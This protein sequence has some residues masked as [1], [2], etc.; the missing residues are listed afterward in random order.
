MNYC[1]LTNSKLYNLT[2]WGITIAFVIGIFFSQHQL[3]SISVLFTSV[4]LL[5]GLLIG[6]VYG[7]KHRLREVIFIITA[8][9]LFATIGTLRQ[10][11]TQPKHIA[12]HIVN[13]LQNNDPKH[14]AFTI[15]RQIKSNE[16]WSNYEAS[17]F[18][19]G[20]KKATGNILLHIT[21][22][23]ASAVELGKNYIAYCALNPIT[24][25]HFP[26]GFH[27]SNYLLSKGITHQVWLKKEVI[28]LSNSKSFFGER[29]IQT[30]HFL[31]RKLE[32]QGLS[33]NVVQFTKALVLGAKAALS[34]EMKSRFQDA[35]VIH[36]LAISGLHIGVIYFVIQWL[37]KWFLFRY[38]YRIL[39][40][41]LVIAII[42][43]FTYFTGGS[44]SAVRASMMFTCFEIS[45]W[46]LR[47]QHPLNALIAAVFILLS[48]QPNY[49]FSV[50]FQLSVTAVAAIMIGVPKMTP[51]LNVKNKILFKIWQIACVT[52]CAQIGILP[53]SIYYFHQIPMLFL[54]ANVPVM[55]CIPLVMS[56]C[57]IYVLSASIA[58]IPHFITFAFNIVIETLLSY[59]EWIASLEAFVIKD[60]YILPLT[61][62]AIYCLYLMARW[63][64]S[65][66][67][68]GLKYVALPISLA[69]ICSFTEFRHKAIKN[70][71]WLLPDYNTTMV[72]LSGESATFYT[73]DTN[74]STSLKN[75]MTAVKNSLHY[76]EVTTET[77]EY[78]YHL[79]HKKIILLHNNFIPEIEETID[80]LVVTNSPKINIAR[81]LQNLQ[82]QKVVIASNNK[83]YVVQNWLAACKNNHIDCYDVSALG[84][85]RLDEL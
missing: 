65:N 1:K 21:N 37:L 78:A 26:Y 80:V 11:L 20:Q 69:L 6:C 85:I 68:T 70:E 5:I 24:K 51:L 82:P 35:G 41:V 63:W 31:T 17:V 48:I 15:T 40:S 2:F 30:R 46:L 47:R 14:V 76:T 74:N 58:E 57:I 75:K 9:L 13:Q 71:V 79:N 45:N 3:F 72:S 34:K 10:Q 42:W 4:A 7:L 54:V 32:Q 52:V 44:D 22:K 43:V 29:I 38:K 60:V 66:F 53:L 25:D 28:P 19:L 64:Y 81:L 77:L 16:K 84:S 67:K 23:E 49:L 83:H 39:K 8:L 73:S 50:G 55:L 62:S 33:D 18:A 12:H 59:I 36:I 61:A 27:Y 56:A